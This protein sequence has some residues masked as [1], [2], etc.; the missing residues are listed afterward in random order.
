MPR[1]AAGLS[2]ALVQLLFEKAMSLETHL[3]PA[4]LE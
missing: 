3:I 4:T 1:P 2:M